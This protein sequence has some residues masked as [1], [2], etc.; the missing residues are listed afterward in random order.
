MEQV[1]ENPNISLQEAEEHYQ[2]SSEN[3]KIDSSESHLAYYRDK[4]PSHYRVLLENV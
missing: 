3:Y 4:H 1:S 2:S